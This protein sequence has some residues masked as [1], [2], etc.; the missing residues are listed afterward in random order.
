MQGLH[1]GLE[2]ALSES[3]DSSLLLN[4]HF[5]IF[6]PIFFNKCQTLLTG[7]V[8]FAIDNGNINGATE[9]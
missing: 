2:F 3:S 8:I 1:T 5:L 4:V 9:R 7:I 6:A